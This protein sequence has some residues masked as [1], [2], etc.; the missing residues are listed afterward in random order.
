MR[1]AP[2]LL[3]FVADD[4][5]SEA[6]S[7]LVVNT[8]RGGLRVAALKTPGSGNNT[9]QDAGVALVQKA[10]RAP[11]I[12]IA[13]ENGCPVAG[14]MITAQV[15]IADATPDGQTEHTA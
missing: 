10:S 6:L 8:L 1:T 15:A 13:L 3:L 7:T 12:R 5:E 9:D 4:M 2:D 14:A 11:L